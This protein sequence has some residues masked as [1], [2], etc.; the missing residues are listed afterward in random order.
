MTF[1]ALLLGC[2]FEH[3]NRLRERDAHGRLGLVCDRC[4]DR[5][6]VNQGA[7]IIG[8]KSK[9]DQVLGQPTARAYSE[10]VTR[11]QKRIRA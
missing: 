11:I 3:A 9:P 6:E 7:I 1:R 10:Q 8:P 5:I 4:G 2:W